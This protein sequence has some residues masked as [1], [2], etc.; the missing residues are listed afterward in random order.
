[1]QE[2]NNGAVIKTNEI[3]LKEVQTHGL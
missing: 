3:G 1:V 2:L